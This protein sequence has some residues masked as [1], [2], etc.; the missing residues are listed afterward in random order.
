MPRQQPPSDDLFARAA[1]TRAL[2]LTWEAVAKE[3]NRAARTVRR[4][5]LKY[6]DRWSAALLQAERHLA[7]QA[8]SESVLTLRRLL[9][10][11]DEWVR[12]HAAKCLIARRLER[13][14]LERKSPAAPPIPL[15]SE[16][17]RLIAFLDGHSDEQLAS[18]ITDLTPLP[19]PATD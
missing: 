12:W 10:S 14:K 3:V 15:T 8:D 11:D 13:D 1:E 18:I 6:A 7:A 5:P 2:G 19:A 17:T 4:W 9:M 16:A